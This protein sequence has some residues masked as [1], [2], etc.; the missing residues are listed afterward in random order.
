MDK[1]ADE[2]LM[3]QIL[4][5]NKTALAFMVERHYPT[6]FYYLYRLTGADQ[7]LAEDLAQDTFLRLMS[8]SSYKPD[9]PFKP[10]LFTIATN[11]VRDHF[12]SAR[13]ARAQSH[14]DIEWLELEDSHPGPEGLTL[15]FEQGRQVAGAIGQLSQ[16]YKTALILRYYHDFTLAEIAQ[17]LQI[18][19]G[20]VKS[21]LSV[22]T[23]QLR[24]LLITKEG[25]GR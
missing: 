7:A 2:Q 21:R 25:T 8:Q 5:G 1:L 10:W 14:N 22:G 11:L 13:I 16:E 24:D 9:K 17:V 4:T 15:Q 18:P 6:V 12:K 3:K 19:L 20:T 23:R